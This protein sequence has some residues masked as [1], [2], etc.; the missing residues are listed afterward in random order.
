[1]SNSLDQRQG[2]FEGRNDVVNHMIKDQYRI[3]KQLGDQ[4]RDFRDLILERNTVGLIN[5]QPYINKSGIYCHLSDLEPKY[6]WDYGPSTY[7]QKKKDFNQKGSH[8]HLFN[9]SLL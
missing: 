1:M 5:Q 8:Y 7:L 3:K 2:F 9:S 4:Q 6:N